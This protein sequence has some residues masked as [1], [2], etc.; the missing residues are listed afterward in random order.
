M[1][2]LDKLMQNL[3]ERDAVGVELY[4][5]WLE[6]ELMLVEILFK[7]FIESGRAMEDG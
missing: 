2:F 4:F 6:I 3:G 5:V 1:D 7:I